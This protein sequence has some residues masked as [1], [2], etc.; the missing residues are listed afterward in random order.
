[1]NQPSPL[2]SAASPAAEP[3]VTL[4]GRLR[5]LRAPWAWSFVGAIGVGMVTASVF[6]LSIAG[7]VVLTALV[8]GVFMVLVGLGQMLVITSG[9][10]N[11]DLSVP[12]VIA[13]A[14]MIGVHVMAAAGIFAGFAAALAAGV[15]V[16]LADYLLIR[17]LRI[18]PSTSFTSSIRCPVC[19]QGRMHVT[20]ILPSALRPRS[21]LP[22]CVEPFR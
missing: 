6:G 5:N 21:P 22:S 10:G 13:L 18:P 19:Q 20:A 1:M 4:G 8:F 2:R 16:G 9:P 15:A 11:I 14:G 7:N 12:S 3:Q 17:V